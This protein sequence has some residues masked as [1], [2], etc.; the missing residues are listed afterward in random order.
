MSSFGRK[1]HLDASVTVPVPSFVRC[2]AT[3][4]FNAFISESLSAYFCQPAISRPEIRGGGI[5]LWLYSTNKH[6]G[7]NLVVSFADSARII[8]QFQISLNFKVS[9]TFLLNSDQNKFK[10]NP[11]LH[12]GP[13]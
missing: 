4:K 6:A 9:N 8:S 1:D 3:R 2:N 7:E 10:S 11:V 12:Y 13:A 5:R